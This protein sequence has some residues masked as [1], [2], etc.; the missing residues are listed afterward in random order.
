MSVPDVDALPAHVW[1]GSARRLPDGSIEI[2]GVSL[3]RLAEE[4]STE[5]APY[6]THV[7]EDAERLRQDC[8]A[9]ERRVLAAFDADYRREDR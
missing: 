2:G 7:E 6:S 4:R 1:P 3:R 9:Q 5:L 8:L